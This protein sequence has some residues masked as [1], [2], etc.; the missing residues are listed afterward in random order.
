[1]NS[2]WTKLLLVGLC[3]AVLS[4]SPGY[5]RWIGVDSSTLDFVYAEQKQ[6]QWCWAA[7]IQ[8]LLNWHGVV[9]SQ[10]EIVARSY[11]GAVNAPASVALMASN[12]NNVSIDNS[13]KLY[14]VRSTLLTNPLFIRS[15]LLESLSHGIPIIVFYDGHAVL[16]TAI[17]VEPLA[18]GNF[19]INGITV[20]DPWPDQWAKANFGKKTYLGGALGPH[21][22]GAFVTEVIQVAKKACSK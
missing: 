10:R 17:D 5:A 21:I 12:L 9:I 8:M 15:A 16:C 2:F 13:G 11:G 22:G 6:S 19:V 14:A 4:V 7:S 18:Y 20:R 3:A 1:M